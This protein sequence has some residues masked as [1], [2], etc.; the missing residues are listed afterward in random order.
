MTA[1]TTAVA[2][3]LDSAARVARVVDGLPGAWGRAV[4][5]RLG[6]L[7]EALEPGSGPATADRVGRV[8]QALGSGDGPAAW[9]TLA[10]LTA[11]LPVVADVQR[12]QRAVRLDGA[13]PPLRSLLLRPRLGALLSRAEPA[14]VEVCSGVVVDL[15]H[16]ART[17]LATGIQR[18][19][20]ETVRRWD[21]DREVVLAGWTDGLTALRRLDPAERRRALTGRGGTLAAGERASGAV[22][23]PWRG[24]YVL[25]ELAPERE[26]TLRLMAMARFA[27][28]RTGVVGL[29]CV[30]ISSAETTDAN[31]SEAFAGYLAA[32][33]HVDRVAGISEAAAA[34]FRGWTRMLRAI[35]TAGPEV[36]A[37]PL[38]AERVA[39]T[40]G[41]L[42]R[43]R[44][45]FLVA[46]LPMLLCV[47][48]AEPR[49]NHLAL[50]HAAETAWRAG[51]RFSLSFVGGHSWSSERF[52]GRLAQLQAQGRPVDSHRGVDDEELWGAYALARA[53]V[54]PSLHE[55]FGLPV[56]EA[57]AVGTP[58]V[59][60]AHGS[61]AELAEG[62]GALLVD[63]R[64]D[65]ALA[66]AL[67]AVVSDD[68]VH[69][70]L[71]LQAV[72]RPE[73]TWAAYADELWSCLVDGRTDRGSDA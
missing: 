36:R 57:L 33:R 8:E 51:H 68:T 1:G 24:T 49:K 27:E 65:G 46:D 20:R 32:L 11:E 61:M 52:V 5:Q 70:R 73:R 29:D 67:S 66:R 41:G 30:P 4:R 23:V 22:L 40:E 15:A 19:A 58:V 39:V 59:T 18:V 37:V 55:G 28:C 31:V 17:D 72:R 54:F 9:L 45:R 7:A 14:E 47:G 25:P 6:A 44:T 53:V 38:P 21:A 62:G 50:L 71:R 3:R 34:E 16:T 56:A 48:T 13:L 26:R 35:G 12:L 69:E 64:D 63:P 2:A 10:V 42:A 60:S 43:A